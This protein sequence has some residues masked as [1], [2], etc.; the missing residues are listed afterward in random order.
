MRRF[1]LLGL[2]CACGN[3][4]PIAT[5][6][7]SATPDASAVDSPAQGEASA[8]VVTP[9][10]AAPPACASDE[11]YAVPPTSLAGW[12]PVL[13]QTGAMTLTHDTGHLHEDQHGPLG[14]CAA[15][16][17]SGKRYLALV[18]ARFETDQQDQN[19]TSSSHCVVD[20]EAPDPTFAQY[21]MCWSGGNHNIYVEVRDESDERVVAGFEVFYGASVDPVSD[22][23][24]P[25]NEVPMNYP[26]AG[27]Q[28]QRY[29]V[30]ATY[31]HPIDGPLASDAVAN[32]RLPLNH[33]V[34]YLFTV[35]VKT[36]P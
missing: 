19:F 26:M 6:D 20:Y 36:K 9:F 10:D 31:T 30:R 23:G 32:L 18:S 24:K 3:D 34:N 33:H 25:A 22:Q 12:S 14:F 11:T 8:D 7:A 35:Q 28:D 13:S 17:Q 21:G 29:G 27:H 16:V 5:N 1:A 15:N 2:L 4:A